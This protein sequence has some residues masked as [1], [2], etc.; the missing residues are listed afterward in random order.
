MDQYSPGFP[1]FSIFFGVPLLVKAMFPEQAIY[2]VS[3]VRALTIKTLED[4]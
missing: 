1:E 2:R 3:K 4:M